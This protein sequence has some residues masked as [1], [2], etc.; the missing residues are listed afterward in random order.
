MTVRTFKQQGAVY[1]PTGSNVTLVAKIDG[2]EVFNGVV[3]ASNNP[4]PVN[5]WTDEV[6]DLFSWSDETALTSSSNLLSS[7]SKEL[8]ITITGGTLLLRDTLANF[9]V[10]TSDTGTLASSGPDVFDLLFIESYNGT[11]NVLTDPFTNVKING[12]PQKSRPE[13]GPMGQWPWKV[14][15]GSTF[16]A[17]VTSNTG[18]DVS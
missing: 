17:T 13:D 12:V 3:P 5:N 14:E 16:T 4:Y 8:E 7:L 18:V 2:Q 10:A 9:C 11:D 15:S 1:A 6:I